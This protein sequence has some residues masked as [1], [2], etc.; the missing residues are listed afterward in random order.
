MYYDRKGDED[1]PQ[2]AI[3]GAVANGEVSREEIIEHFAAEM[4]K[5]LP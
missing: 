5:A 2:G 4:R 3:E 1:L